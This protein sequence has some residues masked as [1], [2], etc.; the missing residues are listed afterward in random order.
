[1][2][3]RPPLPACWSTINRPG[4]GP[5]G[6]GRGGG[7]PQR[8]RCSH[9]R[10]PALPRLPLLPEGPQGLAV[11]PC[12]PPQVPR[13][14]LPQ[15]PCILISPPALDLCPGFL[16]PR[17]PHIYLALVHCVPRSPLPPPCPGSPGPCIPHALVSCSPR[18]PMSPCSGSPGPP[19]PCSPHY[20]GF[21]CPSVPH[22]PLT[23]VPCPPQV[24]ASPH[25]SAL[26]PQVSPPHVPPCSPLASLDSIPHTRARV[27]G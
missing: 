11:S 8:S 6:R 23:L 13:S 17:V 3:A 1:M 12:V 10:F 7:K 9:L 20:P 24:P 27:L 18:C 15:G 4:P 26:G 14:P 2:G 21:P 22:I 16:H 25:L 19:C 5:G